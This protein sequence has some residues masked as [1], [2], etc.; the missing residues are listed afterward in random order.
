MSNTPRRSYPNDQ[1]AIDAMAKLSPKMIAIYAKEMGQSRECG[2]SVIIA[3]EME[4]SFPS[5]ERTRA[6][7]YVVYPRALVRVIT[8]CH[9]SSVKGIKGGRIALF[10]TKVGSRGSI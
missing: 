9:V 4:I 1:C 5:L 6:V 10:A 7:I 8:T 3:M 2:P